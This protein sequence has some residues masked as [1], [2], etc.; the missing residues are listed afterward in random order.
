MVL[1]ILLLPKCCCQKYSHHF[2]IANCFFK[3]QVKMLFNHSF[4]SIGHKIVNWNY[5][6]STRT[7]L[8]CSDYFQTKHLSSKHCH[9][10]TFLENFCLYVF[11]NLFRAI[12]IIILCVFPPFSSTFLNHFRFFSNFPI[13]EDFG[14]IWKTLN[15]D[16]AIWYII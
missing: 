6:M 3:Y 12:F 4:E 11:Y 2:F 9:Y 5:F 10:C 15:A 8:H 16:V 13:C 7:F 1:A 14:D